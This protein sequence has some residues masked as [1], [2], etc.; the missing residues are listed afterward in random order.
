LEE[1]IDLHDSRFETIEDHCIKGEHLLKTVPWFTDAARIVRHH[2]TEWREWGES[3]DTPLTLDSQ[4]VFLGDYIE[5]SIDRNRY[6]LHQ[7]EEVI[8]R[9]RNL[10]GS[11]LHPHVLDMFFAVCE[12]EEFWLDLCS[13][14][15][16]SILLN[17]GPFK[18]TEIKLSKIS[19]IAIL[20]RNI[21]DFRSRFTST[22]SS[23]VA[24]AAVILS[25]MFGLT[26][27]E[28]MLMEVAGNLHDLGKI[29]IPNSILE[30]P[31]PLSKEE[32]AVMKSHTYYTYWIINTIGGIKNIAE[33]A[34]YH[35]ERLDGSGY[36]FHCKANDL[37]TGAR[38]LA[39][40]D[41]FTALAEHR[42]Y[43]K[44]MP[45]KEVMRILEDFSNSS[46]LDARIVRLVSQNYEEIVQEV[47]GKQAEAREFYEGQFAGQ[48]R[49]GL[50]SSGR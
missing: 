5:R 37:S 18:K 12:R 3:I 1:K 8:S 39:V 38:I 28:T 44:G 22:H 36:P 27:L 7:H 16:Y 43:R 4:L 41:I 50:A 45:K 26:E 10:A 11:S 25:K 21:I 24:A 48:V 14:R 42:P 40:A 20:F 34:A 19:L 29:V 13:P 6:I 15:L 35:H 49:W 30:K 9:V 31:E 46:M 23:G 17:E 2:H 32:M 33:W 47:T